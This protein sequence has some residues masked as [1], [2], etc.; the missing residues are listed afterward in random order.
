MFSFLRLT[1]FLEQGDQ[2]KDKKNA[3]EPPVKA[4]N[5]VVL[6]T[7]PEVEDLVK[8]IGEQGDKVRQLKS[9]GADKVGS[10]RG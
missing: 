2:K 6:E 8:K 10:H 7:S 4:G 3:S 5:P 1:S 9:D